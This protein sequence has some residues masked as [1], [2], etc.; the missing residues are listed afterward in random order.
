MRL[1]NFIMQ[2]LEPILQEWERF[3]RSIETPFQSL[4]A[5]ALRNQAE[6]MLTCIA[7]DLRTPQTAQQEYEKS[8]GRAPSDESDAAAHSHAQARWFAGFSLNQVV[9]EYRALRASVLRLWLADASPELAY[10]TDDML[11]FN[12]AIDQLLTESVSAYEEVLEQTRKRV[13]GIVGHDLRS[14]LGAILMSADLLNRTTDLDERAKDLSLQIATSV[15]RANHIVNDMLDLTR[16]NLGEGIAMNKQTVDLALICTQVIR[17]LQAVHREVAIHVEC[18]ETPVVGQF[19]TSR[20]G[21]V[22]S[23]LI[24]NA[25]Q[26]GDQCKPIDVLLKQNAIE[27]VFSVHNQ[28]EPIPASVMPFLFNPDERY[29]RYSDPERKSKAGLGLGLFIANEIVAGHG[30]HIKVKSTRSG[31]TLFQVLIPNPE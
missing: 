27:T 1:S 20:I 28:G 26:H 14:P 21:Q 6:Q 15:R 25:I 19:D 10:R 4:D 8:Q 31:G 23:N 3:A 11:R 13:L 17:E 9:A 29:S 12:E 5:S 24:S 16:C 7:L 2:N 30:G 18:Q 22:F